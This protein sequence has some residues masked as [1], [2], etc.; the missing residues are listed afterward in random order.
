MKNYIVGF[1]YVEFAKVKVKAESQSE[2]ESAVY[3]QLEEYGMPDDADV[4]DREYS[5]D[6][7]EETDNDK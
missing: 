2:A 7:A 3:A 6:Y 5:V 1:S 4:F